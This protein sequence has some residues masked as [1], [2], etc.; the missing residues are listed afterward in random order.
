MEVQTVAELAARHEDIVI[1][2]VRSHGYY[3]KGAM[4]IRGSIRLDPN[5]MLQTLD[6]IPKAK[7]LFLY[8]TCMREATSARVA[9]T[10]IDR[11][12]EAYVIVGGLKAWQKAGLPTEPVPLDEMISLPTFR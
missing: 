9:Q 3:D 1:A 7:R 10:L 2:D 12:F 6:E 11:G 4:R 8:C 5:V